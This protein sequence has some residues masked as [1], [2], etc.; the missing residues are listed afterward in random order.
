MNALID[1]LPGVQAVDE[2]AAAALASWKAYLSHKKRLLEEYDADVAAHTAEVQAALAK[3]E[4]P[5]S[6]APEAPIPVG[7]HETRLAARA[8]EE[9][10]LAMER[11]KAIAAAGGDVQVAA[12]AV[13][14][15]KVAEAGP[16][17]DAVDA[18]LREVRVAQEAVRQVSLARESARGVRTSD[19]PGPDPAGLDDLIDAVRFGRDLLATRSPQAILTDRGQDDGNRTPR[20][21]GRRRPGMVYSNVKQPDS[22]WEP[23]SGSWQSTP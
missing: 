3:G 17:L 15:E 21:G 10:A 20:L 22:G 7:Y 14:A 9:Q 23:R 13:T 12:S 18:V 4:K 8:A 19:G 5:P 2:K 6:G 16:L 1:G 11:M